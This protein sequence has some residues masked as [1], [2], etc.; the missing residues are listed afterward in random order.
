MRYAAKVMAATAI[1]LL[2]D[3]QLLQKAKEEHKQRVGDGYV[4]PIPQGI[5]P[6]AMNCFGKK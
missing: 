5:R 4:P 1:S 3:P 6:R 2:E